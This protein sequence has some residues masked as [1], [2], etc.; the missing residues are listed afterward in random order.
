MT[1]TIELSAENLRLQISPSMGGSISS[2]TWGKDSLP[3]LHSR[4]DDG[5]DILSTASFPLVPFVNRV[6]G[7]TF[8]FGGKTVSLKPNLAGDQSPLHGQGWLAPWTVEDATEASAILKFDH[9]PGEWPW[10]YRSLQLFELD[11]GGLSYRISCTNLSDE[12]M[13][14]GVGIHPYFPCG[15]DTR[16]DTEVSAVW[17]I[18]EHVLPVDKVPAEGKYSLRNRTICGQ[19]LDHGFGGWGGQARVSD[20]NWPFEIS[21]S[22]PSAKFFQVY[23]PAEGG[24]FAAE[25]VTHANA[26][27]NEPEEAWADLGLQVL[28]PGGEM[29]LDVRFDVLATGSR[30]G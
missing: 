21:F 26:A 27:M 29:H 23:S 13:P 20:P 4:I 10:S 28:E 14:C 9:E 30:S 12:P 2:F 24:F 15:P 22:S 5:G 3:I 25:P 19:Q 11:D 17:T 7:G 16:L 8:D 18:D 1:P 6:R